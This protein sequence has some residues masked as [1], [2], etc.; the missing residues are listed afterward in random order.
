MKNADLGRSL[1][2]GMQS[3]MEDQVANKTKALG[4]SFSARC[5]L[6]LSHLRLGVAVHLGD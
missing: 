4:C 5:A 3:I 6:G 1:S 2:L